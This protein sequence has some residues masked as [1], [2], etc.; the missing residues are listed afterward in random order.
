MQTLSPIAVRVPLDHVALG[1]AALDEARF[2]V[3]VAAR[4]AAAIARD[5]LEDFRVLGGEFVERADLVDRPARR[6]PG[7]LAAA[8]S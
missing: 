1:V 3:R 8:A 7:I 6:E 2:V 5:V 4:L